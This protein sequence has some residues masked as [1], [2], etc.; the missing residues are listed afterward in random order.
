MVAL[1]GTS[2]GGKT[3]IAHL[4]LRFYDRTS[5]QILLDGHVITLFNYY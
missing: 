2:G 3:T 4:L 5:G 1:V